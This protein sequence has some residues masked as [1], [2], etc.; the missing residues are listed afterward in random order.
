VTDGTEPADPAPS[1]SAP[2]RHRLRR[3]AR[4]ARA[5]VTT[6]WGAIVAARPRIAALD[7]A[8]DVGERDREVA[9]GLLAGAIAFRL[10]LWL[11]PFAVVVVTLLGVIVEDLDLSQADLARR[12][13]IA[14][15]VARYV[16]DAGTQTTGTI[17]FVLVVSLYALL[18]ASRSSVRALRLAHVLAWRMPVVRFRGTVVAGLWFTAGVT[19]LVL[20]AGAINTVRASRHGPGVVLLLVLMLAVA[21]VW[22]LASWKL[23]HPP[24]VPLRAFVPGT[25]L[26]AV[27]VEALHV[28]TVLYYAGRIEHSSELYGGLGAAVGLLA[29]LYLVGRLAIGSAVVNASLWRR[30]HPDAADAPS[31]PSPSAAG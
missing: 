16:R 11:V 18:I 26:V 4:R 13:G 28:A 14:G 23:P 6:A 1:A 9:G 15:V 2:E 8:F 3:D 10:F 30:S 12:F 24:E 29:W 20:V 7:A 27:G 5:R 22:L 31:S 17:V 19:A 21:A 25:I